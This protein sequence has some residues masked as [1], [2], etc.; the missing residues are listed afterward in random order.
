MTSPSPAISSSPKA[1]L[2]NRPRWFNFRNPRTSSVATVY[3]VTEAQAWSL[4]RCYRGKSPWW[5]MT[6]EW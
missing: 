6:G 2:E 4:L 5:V 1:D 3:A